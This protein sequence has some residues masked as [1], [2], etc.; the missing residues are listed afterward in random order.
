MKKYFYSISFGGAAFLISELGVIFLLPVFFKNF[1]DFHL[2]VSNLPWL[3]LIFALSGMGIFTLIIIMEQ[4]KRKTEFEK[5]K[6]KEEREERKDNLKYDR[7]R[8]EQTNHF[9]NEMEK[10]DKAQ[11]SIKEL[12]SV[13][14]NSNCNTWPT[15]DQMDQIIRYLNEQ[16]LT[17]DQMMQ[18]L[19]NPE[20]N[21]QK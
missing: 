3:L 5:E 7:S 19:N 16:G 1:N 21:E 10:F 8:F 6:L 11:N 17:F 2:L 18:Q 4:Q 12:T 13:I 14:K 20:T 15:K 9:R